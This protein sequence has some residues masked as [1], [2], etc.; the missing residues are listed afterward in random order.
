VVGLRID[1]RVKQASS[2]MA[3]LLFLGLN[4]FSD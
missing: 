3:H 2:S 4:N 1:E